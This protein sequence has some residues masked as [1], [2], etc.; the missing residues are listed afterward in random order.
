M[1]GHH[2]FHV[3][4]GHIVDFMPSV[5][6]HLVKWICNG[7]AREWHGKGCHRTVESDRAQ[8]TGRKQNTLEEGDFEQVI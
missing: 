2:R 7:A 3:R 6:L 1:V 5:H 8:K 4:L